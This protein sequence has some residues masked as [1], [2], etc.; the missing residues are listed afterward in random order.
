MTCQYC[1]FSRQLKRDRR[2]I[3]LEQLHRFGQALHAYQVSSGRD[4]LVCWLGGEPYLWPGLWST[5]QLYREHYGLP[6]GVTTSGI[7]LDQREIQQHTLRWI[8][9]LTIS[10]DGLAAH[11]D[12]ARQ[13]PGGWT[14]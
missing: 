1:G 2:D 10:V 5:T 4:M 11:H 14:S 8:D 7:N 6:I 9:E 3:D 12:W 13:T